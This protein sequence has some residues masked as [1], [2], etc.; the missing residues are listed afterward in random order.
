MPNTVRVILFLSAFY[1]WCVPTLCYGQ[2]NKVDTAF[3]A[4]SKTKSIELYSQAFLNQS[5]LY[6]GSDYIIYQSHDEEHPYF[7]IEDWTNGSIVYEGELY[8]NVDLLYDISSDNVIIEH[9]R[10]NPIKLL[11]EK[12]QSFSL[13]SHKFVRLKGDETNKISEGFYDQLYDGPSKVYAKHWKIYQES[14]DQGEVIPRFEEGNQ[15][16]IVKKG[17]FYAVK[18]KGSVLQVFDDRKQDVKDFIRKNHIRF[19]TDREKAIVSITEFYDI[20]KN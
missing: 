5:R 1:S 3:L 16:Y 20:P 9:N 6:N 18:S 13:L 17:I 2:Q 10:G 4:L 8:N 7:K 15:H 11:D 14:L 12:I 19:K